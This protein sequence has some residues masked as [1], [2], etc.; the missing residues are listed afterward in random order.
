MNSSKFSPL[1]HV[2]PGPPEQGCPDFS[3]S[4]EA[5]QLYRPPCAHAER[6]P[7]A[8]VRGV[9]WSVAFSAPFWILLVLGFLRYFQSK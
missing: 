6:D 4:A 5:G 3:L 8:A 2:A 9:L 7:L 1:R